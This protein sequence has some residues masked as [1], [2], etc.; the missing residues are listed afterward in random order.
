MATRRVSD[1]AE[2]G[3]AEKALRLDRWLWM[4][5]L[6]KTRALAAAAV[7]AGK[8]QVGGLRVR[9]ARSVRIGDALILDMAGRKVELEVLD[10]PLRRGPAPEARACYLESVASI[11]NGVRWRESQQLAALARPRSVG[12]P[13][14]KSRRELIRLARQQGA[15]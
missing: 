8:V 3:H 12:R 13:D 9:A 15:S 6:Y 4:V 14:K 2:L 11:A 1:G 5:R 7:E 10:I